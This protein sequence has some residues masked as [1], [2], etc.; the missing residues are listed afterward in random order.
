MSKARTIVKIF[1]YDEKPVRRLFKIFLLRTLTFEAGKLLRFKIK[2][3]DYSIY[4]HPTA[5]TLAY[6]CNRNAR[7]SDYR[8]ITSYL[9]GGDVYIDVGANVGTTLIA[10]A[11]A[12]KDGKAIGFEPQPRIFSYLKDNVAL[13]QLG[14]VELHNCALG[15]ERGHIS[16][17]LEQLDDRNRPG[18]DGKAIKVPVKW[19]DDF[20]AQYSKIALV[21]MDVEGYEK[22]VCDGG[23]KT[24]EKTGCIY[25]E[26]GEVM[27]QRYGY[28]LKDFLIGLNKK[29]FHL[30]RRKQAGILEPLSCEYKSSVRHINA[31]AIRDIPDFLKR[32][33]WQIYGDK[34]TKENAHET[35]AD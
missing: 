31:F 5:L 10:A 22:F 34:I 30:F 4:L 12:V 2:V 6:W 17:S 25:F 19:L 3:Q 16:F 7:I 8:F 32:T 9:K 27:F 15:S 20:G 11:K 26:M 1:H 18:V 33:G 14:N 13:N 28:S 24:L 21:K 29:G 35:I 23:I